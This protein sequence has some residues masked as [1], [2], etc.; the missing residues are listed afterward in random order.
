MVLYK[1]ACGHLFCLTSTA[2]LI[3][4][5]K[6]LNLGNIKIWLLGDLTSNP[7]KDLHWHM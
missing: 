2:T 1:W 6:A 7:F 4:R 5:I 3:S